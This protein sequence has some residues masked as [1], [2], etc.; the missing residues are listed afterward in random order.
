MKSLLF[1]L[2]LFFSQDGQEA[3]PLWPSYAPDAEHPESGGVEYLR[4]INFYTGINHLLI[5]TKGLFNFT[6]L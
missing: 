3:K 4:L 6:P 5:F 1:R 2:I